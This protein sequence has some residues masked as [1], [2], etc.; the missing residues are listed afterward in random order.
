MSQG[1]P[2][3]PLVRELH[4]G[5]GQQQDLMLLVGRPGRKLP[6]ERHQDLVAT[7]GALHCGYQF[8]P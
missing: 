3:A 2:V 5:D 6:I 8:G 4:F 1:A 7:P